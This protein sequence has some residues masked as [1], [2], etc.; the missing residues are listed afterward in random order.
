M[1]NELGYLY[2]D[3]RV[4]V[5]LPAQAI[6][7]DHRSS[8][9]TSVRVVHEGRERSVRS[10]LIALGANALFN[11]VILRKSGLSH[12][13]LGRGLFEQVGV[14]FDVHLDGIDCFQGS[15]QLTGHGY[16]LY[17]G[18]HRRQRAAGL[19]ETSN[20]PILR[21]Q[22]GRWRE[23]MSLKVIYEDVRQS[24]N[25][26]G[27]DNAGRPYTVFEGISDYT[28][29]AIHRAQSD[30]ERVLSPLPVE[31]IDQRSPPEATQSHVMGTT[32]MGRD[33]KT[34]V[35]DHHLVHHQVRNLVVLGSGAFPTA[36]PANP[37]LTLSAL[38]VWAARQLAASQT[39][40]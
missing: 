13:E 35:L 19:I 26:V 20:K 14:S 15:T 21:M 22:R 1:L 29:R 24:S 18:S 37:T 33:P 31:R 16:M 23:R 27:I 3:P 11:S 32:V 2:D 28:Q 17:H 4:E 39:Q 5:L 34:S 12:P 10:E 38:S 30:V 40:P 6:H 7:I 9:A 25:H 8:V 36:A